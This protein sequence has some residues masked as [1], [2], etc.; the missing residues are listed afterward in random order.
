MAGERRRQFQGRTGESSRQVFVYVTGA[1]YSN[2]RNVFIGLIRYPWNKFRLNC[3]INA[4]DSSRFLY[5]HFI[6]MH[7]SGEIQ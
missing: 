5:L 6:Q 7:F 4:A 1:P 3:I 2:I